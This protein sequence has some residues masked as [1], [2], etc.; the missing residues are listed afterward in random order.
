M[1]TKVYCD[2][3][4]TAILR[5]QADPELHSL[6]TN[7][8]L[9]AGVHVVPLSAVTSDRFKDYMEKWNGRWTSAVAF[10]PTGWTYSPPAGSDLMPSVSRIV[11]SAQSRTF[12]YTSLQLGR[13][14]S[15]AL[16]HYGVP[17]SEHSSFSELTCFAL[18]L[19]WTRIIATVNVGTPTGRAK[20]QSWIDKWD[21]ERKR[22]RE[23]GESNVVEYRSLDYW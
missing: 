15:S 18:S 7:N 16:R 4:K 23:A 6:L 20:M 9:E 2:A 1:N 13:N 5:C 8:P 10:R 3:R 12:S 22:R 21:A 17:Y 19:D 11:A 14:S